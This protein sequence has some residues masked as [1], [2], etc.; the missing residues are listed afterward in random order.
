MKVVPLGR[1][2]VTARLGDWRDLTERVDRLARLQNASFLAVTCGYP[3]GYEEVSLLTYYGDP[4]LPVVPVG[5]PDRWTF[6]TAPSETLLGAPGI[7][8]GRFG[9]GPE[10]ELAKH[11]QRVDEIARLARPDGDLPARQYAIF[12]V[13][14]LIAP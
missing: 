3:G 9:W 11:F 1:A 14:G 5:D 4:T 13:D 12:S 7:G 10:V 8:F 6:E 2:D